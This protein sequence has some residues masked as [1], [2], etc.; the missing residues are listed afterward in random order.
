MHLGDEISKLERHG[1]SRCISGISRW[2]SRRE[3][4]RERDEH[5]CVCDGVI[6]SGSGATGVACGVCC[7]ACGVRRAACGVCCVLCGVWRV[8]C[9][10]AVGRRAAR[11][12]PPPRENCAL[13]LVLGVAR[14]NETGRQRLE[15]PV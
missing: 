14:G 5:A 12:W 13:A 9:G 15:P 10:E 3:R 4:P 6:I 11:C 7:V 8:A 1:I 2:V